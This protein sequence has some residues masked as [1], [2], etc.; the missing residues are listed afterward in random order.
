M[1][2][3]SSEINVPYY[4]ATLLPYF[5][6]A[7]LQKHAVQ[8]FGSWFFRGCVWRINTCVGC[9]GVEFW[10]VQVFVGPFEDG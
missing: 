10:A 2:R 6:A 5:S 3:A 7:W 9:L 8:F 4:E 1:H